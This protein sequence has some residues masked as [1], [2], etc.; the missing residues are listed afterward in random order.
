M[1]LALDRGNA[2]PMA[3][4]N[5]A[6]VKM[7]TPLRLFIL[8]LIVFIINFA[9]RPNGLARLD[10]S[11]QLM[12]SGRAPATTP[13]SISRGS[14]AVEFQARRPPPSSGASRHLLPEGEGHKEVVATR[15][16]R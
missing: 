13:G 7:A 9:R 14:A 2:T 1:A 16:S 3:V 5:A 12:C 8:N 4:A 10:G 15:L 11:I 6:R